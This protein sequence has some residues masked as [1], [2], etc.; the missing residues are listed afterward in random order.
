MNLLPAPLASDAF[1]QLHKT[2]LWCGQVGTTVN[3]FP[4]TPVHLSPPTT[5][6][7]P[8]LQVDRHVGVV[9]KFCMAGTLFRDVLMTMKTVVNGQAQP[10][11]VCSF[12]NMLTM[13][14]DALSSVQDRKSIGIGRVGQY[15]IRIIRGKTS[16]YGMRECF[17]HRNDR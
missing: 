8:T 4:L 16:W 13:T 15:F 2:L 1:V 6:K 14:G 5:P 11:W 12:R 7:D 10:N 3:A 17:C 9:G